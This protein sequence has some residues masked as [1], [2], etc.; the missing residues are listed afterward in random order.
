MLNYLK[1]GF[2]VALAALLA[3]CQTGVS[4]LSYADCGGSCSDPAKQQAIYDEM[5]RLIDANPAAASSSTLNHQARVN[6]GL[7]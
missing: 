7:D 5:Q 1:I 4:P 3:A 2:L 6:L